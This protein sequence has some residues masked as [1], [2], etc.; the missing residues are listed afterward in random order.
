MRILF[1]L[2]GALISFSAKA[3]CTAVAELRTNELYIDVSDNGCGPFNISFTRTIGKDGSP[4]YS[5]I[6]AYP[7]E[8]ECVLKRDKSGEITGFSCHKNGRTP[9]AGATYRKKQYGS[10]Q[11]DCGDDVYERPSYRY[12]CI[13]GCEMPSVPKVLDGIDNY[14]D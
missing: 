2:V 7:F 3:G 9:L 8:S 10:S 12:V 5:T 13:A 6:K 14:C 4:V 11:L 1:F